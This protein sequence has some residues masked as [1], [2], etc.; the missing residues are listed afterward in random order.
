MNLSDRISS[1][2]YLLGASMGLNWTMMQFISVYEV[3]SSECRFEK[4]KEIE[5]KVNAIQKMVAQLFYDEGH[6]K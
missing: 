2:S 6:E 3:L 1:V 4:F 5:S